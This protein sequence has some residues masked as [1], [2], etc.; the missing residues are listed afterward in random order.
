M[1]RFFCYLL[2]LTLIMCLVGC[3]GN[4]NGKSTVVNEKTFFENSVAQKEVSEDGIIFFKNDSFQLIFN[5]ENYLI[6]VKDLRN[7]FVW[8]SNFTDNS[9]DVVAKGTT[10]TN[11]LSQIIINYISGN[12]IKSAN[13]YAT[14]LRKGELKYTATESG[15]KVN[16]VFPD[17]EITVPVEY[18]LESDG[19]RATVDFAN[20]KEG[21][22]N[23]LVSVEL[24]PYFGT[25]S[26]LKC[27]GYAFVPDGSGAVINFDDKEYGI[28]QT[29]KKRI[30]G[31]DVLSPSS[32]QTTHECEVLVPVFGMKAGDNG[33]V[34]VI[35]NGNSDSFICA[36]AAGQL[37]RG[38]SV[39]SLGVCR[40]TAF[41]DVTMQNGSATS[42]LFY[43][44]DTVKDFYSVK[45]TMLYGDDANYV[46]MANA[47]RKHLEKTGFRAD[48][49]EKAR[50]FVDLH[51][52]I[53]KQS[54]FFGIPYQAVNVLTS[55]KDAENLL[56]T[57]QQNG[58]DSVS[59]GLKDF[60]SSAIECKAQNN[61]SVSGKLGNKKELDLFIKFANKNG[62]NIY[63]T[64]DFFDFKECGNGIGGN[65]TK[66][67]SLERS[68]AKL[69]DFTTVDNYRIK[70]GT[71]NKFIRPEKYYEQATKIFYDLGKSDFD[72]VGLINIASRLTS[73][74]SN[75]F[76]SRVVA[77]QYVLKATKKIAS[78]YKLMCYA[79]NDYLW[80]SC[81]YIT[82][83][84][85]FSSNY[86]VF[87]YDVPFL[88]IVL[89]GYKNFSGTSLNL[90][91]ATTES[92]LKCIE[93]GSD[94]KFEG[95]CSE[96]SEIKSTRLDGIYGAN[97]E[98]WK[99]TATDWYKEAKKVSDKVCKSRIVSHT[100]SDNV[101]TVKY[102]NGVTIYVNYKNEDTEC[103]GVNIPA[104]WYVIREGK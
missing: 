77:K 85:S 6:S 74:Y 38:T 25:T 71:S 51:G 13:S 82:D 4:N 87:S 22:N 57:L 55:V 60:T 7:G 86:T 104:Q 88:Q 94:L 79:P 2:V 61:V 30:Y 89:K 44:D 95:I 78:E 58:V 53:L 90:S 33:Y 93:T 26:S 62:V 63:P 23:K 8:E 24:L 42:S 99:K 28:K 27:K 76:V 21:K 83:I 69:Y 43:S 41:I 29:Y 102:S 31:E 97:F 72:K 91:G 92:F 84:P 98:G 47:Y 81:E 49:D 59:L 101:A 17:I 35:E 3:S 16:Y 39:Y 54:S 36:S 45:Y 34:A 46:G 14:C 11:M 67:Y 73:D 70:Q 20:I 64:A 52:G 96:N 32:I 9:D 103:D 48:A 19:F 1:K 18:S 56:K 5:P 12:E 75:G 40:T 37:T 15:I 10:K 68:P 66:V 80:S 100:F 50:L 65:S